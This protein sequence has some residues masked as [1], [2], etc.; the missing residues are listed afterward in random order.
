VFKSG[1]KTFLFSRAFSLLRSTLP[2]TSSSEVT[3][4]GAI[5][6]RLLLLLLLLLTDLQHG[7]DLRNILRFIV[8]L[9]YVCRKPCN[10]MLVVVKTI[11]YKRG[12]SISC[13]QCY[14]LTSDNCAVF[15]TSKTF[16]RTSS[17]ARTC[18]WLTSAA[19]RCRG[20]HYTLARAPQ[21]D[22]ITGGNSSHTHTHT[23]V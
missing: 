1:L 16:R 13:L 21:A 9:S 11:L 2:G 17:T 8:R 15:Q 4:Y 5:Q 10:R 12:L 19:T 18:R 20:T 22:C 7:P 14:I 23:P 3:T 6:V